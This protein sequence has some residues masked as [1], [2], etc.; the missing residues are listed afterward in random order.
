[1]ITRIVKLTFRE[2]EI[3][4]FK[5][6][7]TEVNPKIRLQPGCTHLVGY[8]DSKNPAIFFTY[9]KWNTEQA[10]D[11]YKHSELFVTT[12]AKTKALFASKPEAWSIIEIVPS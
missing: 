11:N 10:L 7:F 8:Q 2:D 6:I 3:E 4:N 12:W 9:S 1:M 5:K